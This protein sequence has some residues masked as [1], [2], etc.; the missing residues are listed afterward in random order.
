MIDAVT[1]IDSCIVWNNA[2]SV[3]ANAAYTN[4]VSTLKIKIAIPNPIAPRIRMGV[5]VERD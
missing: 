3:S 5:M 1:L 4:G 2:M